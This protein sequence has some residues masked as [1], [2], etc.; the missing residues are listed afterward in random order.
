VVRVYPYFHGHVIIFIV[1][2]L[3]LD[4]KIWGI[5]VGIQM[6][7]FSDDFHLVLTSWRFLESGFGSFHEIYVMDMIGDFGV[8]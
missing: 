6:G 4:V 1:D 8:F 5:L 7:F 3:F 2:I